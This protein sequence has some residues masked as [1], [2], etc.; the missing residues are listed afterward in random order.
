MQLQV[1]IWVSRDH[2]QGAAVAAESGET[3]PGPH[4]GLRRTLSLPLAIFYGLGNILG[5]GIY[6]LV[7]KVAAVAG[8]FTPLS[9]LL[10]GLVVAA[11]AFTYAELVSRYPRSAGEAVY[12]QQAF[13][14]QSLSLVVGLMICAAGIVSSAAIAQGFVGYL[15]IFY[16]TEPM[17]T[18]LLVVSLLGALASWGISQSVRV[19]AIIT[20]LEMAGL[21]LV[22]WIGSELILSGRSVAPTNNQ[23]ALPWI[24][25]WYGAFL[26]FYAF[27]G[28]EDMVNVA[29]EVKHPRV[30]LPVAILIA[31]LIAMLMYGSVSYVAIRIVDPAQLAQSDAPLATIVAVAT[32]SK[33]SLIAL[34]AML[35]VIN[36]ALVQ[37]I[38]VSR[39]LYGMGKQLW[40]PAV[41][42]RVHPVT[43]TPI[44]STVVVCLMVMVMAALFRIESLAALTSFIILLVFALINLALIRIKRAPADKLVMFEVPLWV[45]VLGLLTTVGLAIFSIAY[46]ISSQTN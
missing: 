41:F 29:E 16:A 17:V 22:V 27:L 12:V 39:I 28:F 45:P 26:A 20:V 36:G 10:S 13:G 15:Q 2:G 24:G 14:Y 18:V 7:G 5:A 30:Y 11:T 32:G 46:T 23:V 6:V 37:M 40:I 9:F 19:V 35:A 25:I 21:L 1:P 33:G 4:V 31:L 42:A 34:I 8:Y 43:R 3:G 38:M 44:F